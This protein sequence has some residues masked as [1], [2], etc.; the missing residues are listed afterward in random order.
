[1]LLFFSL[2]ISVFSDTFF[3]PS[4]TTVNNING[5]ANDDDITNEGTVNNDINGKNGKDTI[6]NNGTVYGNIIGNLNDGI[7]SHGGCQ[8]DTCTW[9]YQA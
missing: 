6:T 8:F 4:G 3:N 7:G 9:C 1:M 5:T 2:P